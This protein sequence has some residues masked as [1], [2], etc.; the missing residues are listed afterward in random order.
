MQR[1]L[2]SS[3]N[4]GISIVIPDKL[5]IFLTPNALSDN[6]L[7]QDVDGRRFFSAS[8]YADLFEFMQVS[9]VMRLDATPQHDAPFEAKGM[10]VYTPEDLGCSD[11]EDLCSLEALDRFIAASNQCEGLLALQC[12]ARHPHAYTL[13]AAYMVR[14]RHFASPGDAVAWL[15]MAH[16]C[17]GCGGAPGVDYAVLERLAGSGGRGRRASCGGVMVG[18]MASFDA[19]TLTAASAGAAAA[20]SESS[21]Q[22]PNPPTDAAG[23]LGAR[24]INLTS[25]SSGSPQSAAAPRCRGGSAVTVGPGFFRAMAGL[26]MSSPNILAEDGDSERS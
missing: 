8:F 17:G 5:L 15:H 11:D 18:A 14:R 12:D 6:N 24:E 22:T 23:P 7:W 25:G 19:S 2:R 21:I 16:A 1:A 9:H 10:L 3:I 26:S 20:A 13:V 4:G